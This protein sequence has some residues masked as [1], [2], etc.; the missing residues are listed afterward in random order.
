M[1]SS[2]SLLTVT[3]A[4]LGFIH[5]ILGV[6]HYVPFIALSKSLNW[7]KLKTLTITAL[8]G[9]GHVLSTVI[10]GIIGISLGLSLVKLEAIENTRGEIAGW[11]L[12]IFGLAYTI[13]G[14][15]KAK[16]KHTHSHYHL[17]GNIT[18]SHE[19]SHDNAEHVH[20]HKE[21][22]KI[23]GWTLF[24]IFVFG[25]CE[26]LIPV[27]MIPAANHSI[28]GL[29]IVTTIF[30]ITTILTMLV[31]VLLGLYGIELLPQKKLEK[32]I[33]TFAGI[34]ILLC[35]IGVQFLGL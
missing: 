30:G 2:L 11:L 27:L 8:C 12:I 20:L 24:I 10:I 19:H 5:T 35:G 15:I 26:A 22:E 33:H 7:S 21:P 14:I 6:D 23:S 31:M 13:Y 1:E 25:P 3:A 34:T 16:K 17:D 32:H 9:V 28:L 4:S 29:T 18:H